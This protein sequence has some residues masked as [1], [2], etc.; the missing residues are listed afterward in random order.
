M[1]GEMHQR[2]T[3]IGSPLPLL[4]HVHQSEEKAAESK[5]A[6]E[7]AAAE[8]KAA[9]ERKVQERIAAERAAQERAA[10]EKRAAIERIQ[11]KLLQAAPLPAK[12]RPPSKPALPVKTVAAPAGPESLRALWRQTIPFEPG[13]SK[14]T[15]ATRLKMAARRSRWNQ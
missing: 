3:D 9:D 4:N 6:E 10:Q 13:S 1:G 8:A 14:L 15:A 2:R 11:V 7:R 5:A 12:P